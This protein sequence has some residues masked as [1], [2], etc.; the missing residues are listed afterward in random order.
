MQKYFQKNIPKIKKN[1]IGGYAILETLFYI[2]FFAVFSIVVI[3]AMLTMVRSFKETSIHADLARAGGMMERM[4]REVKQAYD[5]S[6]I[7]GTDLI[8]N[9][10]D[11]SGTNKTIQ[12]QLTG[13]NIRLLDNG[14]FIAN[15]NSANL[16]V[17]NLSFAQITTTKGKAVKISFTAY[18][19][20]DTASR[21]E[22]FYNTVALRGI[23]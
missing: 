20:R 12:F 4:S 7:S 2:S 23:Y 10:T 1:K 9:T 8:L 19:T 14:V 6:S 21:P 13:N 11:A 5:I 17:T 18:S 15:L 22:T 3:Q 16:V